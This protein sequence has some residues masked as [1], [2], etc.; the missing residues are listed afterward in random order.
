MHALANVFKEVLDNPEEAK[1]LNMRCDLLLHLP[2]ERIQRRLEEAGTATRHDPEVIL[3]VSVEQNVP[4]LD[5]DARHAVVQ[6]SRGSCTVSH[7]GRSPLGS[8][9]CHLGLSAA[10]PSEVTPQSDHGPEWPPPD[11]GLCLN[12]YPHL[13]ATGQGTTILFVL[14]QTRPRYRFIVFGA[15]YRDDVHHRKSHRP[16]QH[17]PA[18]RPA[19][20]ASLTWPR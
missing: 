12:A 19:R 4:V 6:V 18:S 16:R 8:V 2:H 15:D 14:G 17:P 13:G 10:Q 11:V 1:D 9:P 5:T 20:G 3:V 7:Q